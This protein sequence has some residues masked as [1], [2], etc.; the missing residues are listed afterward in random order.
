MVE[1]LQD[2]GNKEAELASYEQEM[3]NVSSC[4]KGIWQT[5]NITKI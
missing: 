2:L 4:N 3:K 5:L 1:I